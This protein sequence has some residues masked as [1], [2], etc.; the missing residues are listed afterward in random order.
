MDSDGSFETS[1]EA[2][3][4]ES[5]FQERETPARVRD[6]YQDIKNRTLKSIEFKEGVKK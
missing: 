4:V 6:S 2:E 3:D 5:I 1:E